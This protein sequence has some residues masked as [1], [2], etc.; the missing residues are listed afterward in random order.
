[1]RQEVE[2]LSEEV[3]Y[4]N[5]LAFL[6]LWLTPL[7]QRDALR[8]KL[9][10]S[11][12]VSNTLRA[13]SPGQRPQSIIEDSKDGMSGVVQRLVAKEKEVLQLRKEVSASRASKGRIEDVSHPYVVFAVTALTRLPVETGRNS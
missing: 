12:A 3:S 9:N 4:T 1:L 13:L 2:Q 11:T 5:P 10:E 6:L 8:S 7:V